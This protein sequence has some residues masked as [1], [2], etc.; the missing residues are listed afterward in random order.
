[1]KGYIGAQMIIIIAA[2]ELIIDGHWISIQAN[3]TTIK[4]RVQL[5]WKRS[6]RVLFEPQSASPTCLPLLVGKKGRREGGNN[7]LF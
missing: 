6:L 1:M 5:F 3:F 7:Y 4:T 2:R